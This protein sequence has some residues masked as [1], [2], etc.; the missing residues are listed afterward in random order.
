MIQRLE[1]LTNQAPT[2]PEP[3]E[4]A[5]LEDKAPSLKEPV[6]RAQHQDPVRPKK[7]VVAHGFPHYGDPKASLQWGRER[8]FPGRDM[9]PLARTPNLQG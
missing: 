5:A 1:A 7:P 4:E 6:H 2:S 9:A 8:D 3:A